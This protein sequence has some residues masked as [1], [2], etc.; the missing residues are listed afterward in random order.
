MSPA[1][2]FELVPLDCPSCGASVEADAEDVVF[3]CVAC[4]NGYRFDHTARGL[5][6]LDVAFVSA[7][8]VAARKYAPFWALEAR[9]IIDERRS[10]GVDPAEWLTRFFS[11]GSPAAESGQGGQGTF[12]VPAFHTSLEA[13]LELTR[14]YTAAFPALG[15]K[16]GERLTGGCYGIEDARK[17]THFAVIAAEV[18]RRDVLQQLRYRIEFGSSRLLGVPL[19]T[20]DGVWQDGLFGVAI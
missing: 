14:R 13:T 20:T 3:Y 17:L 10:G 16:L 11:G 4:R 5:E 7:P 9:V 15:E 18:E 12:V 6:P 2:E 8:N 1:S 19:V